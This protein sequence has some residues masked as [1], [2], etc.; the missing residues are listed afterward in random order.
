[1]AFGDG[2]GSHELPV[3]FLGYSLT[4]SHQAGNFIGALDNSGYM[5][6]LAQ[7][8][9]GSPRI[10]DLL[11]A[12]YQGMFAAITVALT[13]GAVCERGRI[14][15]CVIFMFIWSTIVYDPIACW[16]WNPHGWIFKLGGLDFAGGTPVHISSGAAALAYSYVLG[17]CGQP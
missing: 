17:L 14:L 3:V 9:V 5:N 7:P 1:M 12:V 10:P 11:F 8:S 16:T 6:V 2:N 13:V 15:P 4:F